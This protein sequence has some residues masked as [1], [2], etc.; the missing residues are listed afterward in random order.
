M[1]SSANYFISPLSLPPDSDK[2]TCVWGENCPCD[3]G[4][5]VGHSLYNSYLTQA[6]QGLT[7]PKFAP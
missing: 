5:M 3:Q 4:S 6:F 2:S 7:V 1:T